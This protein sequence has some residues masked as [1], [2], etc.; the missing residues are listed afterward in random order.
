V[1]VN[2][3]ALSLSQSPPLSVPL[4]F[5]LTAPLFII[6]AA[7]VI[8]FYGDNLFA[9]RW[10][11]AMLALTHL[12][13][14]GFLGSCMLGALQQLLPVLLGTVLPSP[15]RTSALL[16]I[17]WT[18]GSVLLVLGMGAGWKPGLQ[19][20]ALLLGFAL[21]VLLPQAGT[22]LWRTS[23]RHATRPAMA[24]ALFALAAAF[25]MAVTL[26]LKFNWQ[27]PLAH[28]WSRYHIGWAALGWV[29]LLVI[30][31]AYQVVPMFQITP[32][33]PRRIRQFLVPL[34]GLVLLLWPLLPDNLAGLLLAA[35]MALFAVQTLWLQ[36]RR[37]RRL[38]DVTLDFWRL[39]MVSLLLTLV[40]WVSNHFYPHPVLELAVGV[41][42]LA[43]FAVSAVNG[44]LYK[45]VPFLVWL[46]LNNQLQ[47]AGSWQGKVP[48]MKQ[49]IP[50]RQARRQFWL[51][52]ASLGMFLAALVLAVPPHVVA[53]FWLINGS[54]LGWNLL[55]ALR[56]FQRTARAVE[57]ETK[58][59]HP[60]KGGR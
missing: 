1:S 60:P 46:H 26:L 45:I 50:E 20:G 35:G 28:P 22:A 10:T 41:L 37:R 8:L 52:L 40:L 29:G 6:A 7:L 2:Y 15:A 30:G 59:S 25:L 57:E 5:F 58:A 47:Q 4:R 16:H 3:T 18:L 17:L 53:V 12:I 27:V 36:S 31:V 24:L 42:F 32:E 43:G 44:M 48:N 54:W 39:A 49:V 51:H 38:A 34:L 55:L 13:T 33:Y 23:S 9:S 56:V 14:L 11:P 19:S 21:A